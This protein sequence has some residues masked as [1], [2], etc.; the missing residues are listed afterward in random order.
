MLGQTVLQKGN[1]EPVKLFI[2]GGGGR[3]GGGV[4]SE[5]IGVGD[6]RKCEVEGGDGGNQDVGSGGDRRCGD[7]V[8]GG[9][10]G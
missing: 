3:E 4:G 7:E 10:G 5:W 6:D 2:E 8:G 1:N 9:G